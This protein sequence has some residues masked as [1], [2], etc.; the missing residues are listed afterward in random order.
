M[1]TGLGPLAVRVYFG[2][3]V[4]GAVAGGETCCDR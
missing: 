3:F 1:E 2:V 4:E